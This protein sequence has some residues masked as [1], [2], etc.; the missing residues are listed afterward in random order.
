[1]SSLPN[2]LFAPDFSPVSPGTFL[3][4]HIS[5]CCCYLWHLSTKLL[6]ANGGR[7]L[8]VRDRMDFM[9]GKR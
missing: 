4:Q 6:N 7:L 1:M 2:Q 9:D 5:R 3:L 8:A